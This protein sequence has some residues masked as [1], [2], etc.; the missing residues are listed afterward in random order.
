MNQPEETWRC[1]HG[2]LR[3][4]QCEICKETMDKDKALKLALAALE[5]HCGNYKLDDEG[6][7]RFVAACKAI[8]AAL[9]QDEQGRLAKVEPCAVCGE[10]KARLSVL[11]SCD[12]C[13]SEYAGQAEMKVALGKPE[14][15]PVTT[16]YK[17]VTDTMNLL[18]NGGYKQAQM[19][20]L[21]ADA[22]LYTTPPKR[23]WVG[24]TPDE[25]MEIGRELGLKCRL[26]G[27]PNI[28]FDYAN[29]IEAKLKSKNA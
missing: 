22:K 6:V 20:Q 7:E 17:E 11:R 19:A 26:G 5:N 2:W 3:G 21:M 1:P 12:T 4:E 24:L 8:K 9:A 15:E 28:D 18:L 10:G 23:E 16:T 25:I 29:A 14:Q 13:H 27:N